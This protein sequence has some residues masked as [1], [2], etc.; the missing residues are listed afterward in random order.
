[1]PKAGEIEERLFQLAPGE[2]TM[3]WDNVGLLLGDPERSVER[4]LVALDI[5]EAVADEAI[6][7]D[8]QMIVAHHPIMNCRWL[9][10]QSIREDTPQGHL[11]RKLLRREICAVCMHTNLDVAWGGVNDAL[12]EALRLEDPGPLCENGLGRVGTLPQPMALADFARFV[13]RALGCNGLRYADAGRP[14]CRVGVGGGACGDFAD[15]AIAAGC[16]TYVTADLSYHQ[17]L[18]A[19]GK[20]VNL[21]DAGHFPTENPVCAKLISFLTEQFPALSVFKSASHREVIQYYVEG[22]S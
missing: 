8:C 9:P 18:D 10:V 17:F 7:R 15:D 21:I 14:V 1:M 13:S 12:A 4:V 22:E 20:G 6:A 11:L 19:P 3:D 16:D 2:G 5:T